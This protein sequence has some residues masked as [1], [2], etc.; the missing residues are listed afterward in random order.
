MDD[1]LS[2]LKTIVNIKY[3][4][5]FVEKID[6]FFPNKYLTRRYEA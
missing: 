3:F 6:F 4:I 1:D 5:Y 2:L